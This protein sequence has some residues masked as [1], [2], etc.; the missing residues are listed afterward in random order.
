MTTVRKIS[1]N[2]PIYEENF[3]DNAKRIHEDRY[4]YSD[5]VYINDKYYFL[6]SY[7]Y[8]TLYL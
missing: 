5:M 2:R 4:D 7:C 8:I 6:T 3:L 1:K